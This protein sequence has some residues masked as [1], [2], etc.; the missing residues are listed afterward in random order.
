M[1]QLRNALRA[2]ALVESSPAEVVARLN[3]LVMSGGEDT[4]ATVLFLLFDRETGELTFTS[5][6]H[7][8]PLVLGP[9][10]PRFLE[11]GRSMPVGAADAA[12]FREGRA[13]L[14]PGST[15][16]LYTDGLVE[17]RDVALDE[18]LDELTRAASEGQGGLEEL[19]DRV[20]QGVLGAGEPDDDVA[21]LVVRAQ[22]AA[23][24]LELRL[25]AEPQVLVDLRRRLGRFLHAA[26]ASEAEIYEITLTISEAA[27]NAI[28]HAY[29]PG[30]AVFEVEAG[31]EGGELVALVRDRGS[32]RER[33]G[34]HR[35]RGLKII[36]GLMDEVEVASEEDGTVV[37]MRRRLSPRLAA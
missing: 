2:Y 8:P 26:G 31:M 11:E 14:A 22:P 3:R 25:P 1:G 23:E 28:E 21:L 32:W 20:L 30:D 27:G 16:L 9:D 34:A 5:A 4:M 6:G 19:C 17:R 33:R 13:T 29:G 24:R 15:L 7:P 12:V 35:G 10:G 37:R 36:E 18:R